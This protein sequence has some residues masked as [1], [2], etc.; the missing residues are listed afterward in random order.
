MVVCAASSVKAVR[1][2]NAVVTQIWMSRVSENNLHCGRTRNRKGAKVTICVSCT[3]HY[4]CQTVLVKLRRP[5]WIPE[6]NFNKAREGPKV[7]SRPLCSFRPSIKCYSLVK[8]CPSRVVPAGPSASL[9]L[10]TPVP[11][12]PGQAA[13]EPPREYAAGVPPPP[14]MDNG[15][16]LLPPPCSGRFAMDGS[17]WRN[18]HS[19]P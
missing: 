16:G 13:A 15:T 7:K 5:Q 9:F 19:S 18:W 3:Q 1:K 11:A 14:A 12:P 2:S 17:S 8:S 6:L 10:G 4:G